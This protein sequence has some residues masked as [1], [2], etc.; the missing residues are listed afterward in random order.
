MKD[1]SRNWD[2]LKNN[3]DYFETADI[4]LQDR[5][6]LLLILKSFFQK[7]ISNRKPKKILDLGTGNGILIKTLF[8]N[9]D[10]QNE[11]VVVDGSENMINEAKANLNYLSNVKFFN[12]S[13]QEIIKNGFPEKDFNFI[14]SAF[15]IHHLNSKEKK[16]FYKIIF[17]LLRPN[18]YFVNID[19]TTSTLEKYTV[20]FLDLWSEWINRYQ[21]DNKTQTSFEKVPYNAPNKPENHYDPLDM[22]LSYL[23]EIGFSDVECFYKYGLFSIFGGFKKKFHKQKKV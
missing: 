16:E 11:I 23:K 3:K 19:T 10:I 14:I 8:N 2:K 20:W 13:F 9:N 22:Q 5:K 4:I 18:G 17:N 6:S 15:A 12:V 7:Y 1:Y 21:N